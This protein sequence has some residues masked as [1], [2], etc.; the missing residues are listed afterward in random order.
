MHSAY[1]SGTYLTYEMWFCYQFNR[2]LSLHSEYYGWK[3][4]ELIT[5]MAYLKFYQKTNECDQC[6][7][8]KYNILMPVS[9]R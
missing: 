4:T 3:K 2:I 6:Q 5:I 9:L 1:R 8:L 7:V